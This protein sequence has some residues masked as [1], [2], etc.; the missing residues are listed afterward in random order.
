MR[1]GTCRSH[2]TQ[3]PYNICR[4]IEVSTVLS[5]WR[6]G[7]LSPCRLTSSAP[8]STRRKRLSCGLACCHAI[9]HVAWHRAFKTHRI[10]YILYIKWKGQTSDHDC[11]F[12]E[13]TQKTEKGGNSDIWATTHGLKLYSAHCIRYPSRA[14]P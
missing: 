5:K 4:P 6:T 7:S 11:S 12:D 10:I 9:A 8:R 14:T 2:C 1:L 3:S 13:A